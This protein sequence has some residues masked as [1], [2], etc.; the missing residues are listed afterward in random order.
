M[1]PP[2]VQSPESSETSDTTELIRQQSNE[3]ISSIQ[4]Y[5]LDMIL[6]A[7]ALYLGL[8][9]IPLTDA[10]MRKA[11]HFELKYNDTICQALNKE[12]NHEFLNEVQR[13]TKYYGLAMNIAGSLPGEC[14]PLTSR[15]QSPSSSARIISIHNSVES[16]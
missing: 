6:A 1:E 2:Q 15:R 14:R 9:S 4:R 13:I 8:L 5:V 7:Y 12:E 10:M 16:S 11:C 3:T